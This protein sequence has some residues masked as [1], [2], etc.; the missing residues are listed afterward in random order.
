V[1]QAVYEFPWTSGVVKMPRYYFYCV[2]TEGRFAFG[3]QIE[4]EDIAA[5]VLFLA[6]D[7]VIGKQLGRKA[8]IV[9]SDG[10]DNGS[11]VS[12]KNA[13]MTDKKLWPADLKAR[14]HARGV[15]LGRTGRRWRT[16]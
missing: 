3:K 11:R 6:S 5:A 2:N 8:L 15:D 13:I 12:L 10:E 14:G 7:E 16:G 1:L 4:A 9:L